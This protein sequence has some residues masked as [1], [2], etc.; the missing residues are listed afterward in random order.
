MSSFDISVQ[1]NIREMQ[2]KLGAFANQQLPFATS[3][4][5]TALA[6]KVKDA[7]VKNL[8]AKLTSP[9]PFTL[10]SIGTTAAR[11]N[12]PQATVFVKAAAAAYLAPFEFGGVHKMNGPKML[13]PIGASTNAY[14][15]L[16]KGTLA[17][18]K[19]RKDIFIGIV[20]TKSGELI[21]GVWQRPYIRATKVRGRG[22]ARGAN[23]TGKLK[24][25]IRL[26]SEKQV[27]QRIGY[28][29]LAQRTVALNFN[30]EMGK[31]LAKALASAR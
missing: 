27:R 12:A 20:K 6:K 22:V 19:A 13:N 9:T 23:R 3:L 16:P 5:L 25:L 18:L 1:S 29:A 21:N 14:G 11:K 2:R 8:S 10:R 17:K 26:D 31:A 24:L 30:A 7:E 28:V 15:N 4:A